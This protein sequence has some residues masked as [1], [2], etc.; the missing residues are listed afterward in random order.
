[1]EE[2]L[3]VKQILPEEAGEQ[4]R[5]GEDDGVHTD[6]VG[7]TDLADEDKARHLH[8]SARAAIPLAAAQSDA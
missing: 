5:L 4:A 1:M 3:G 7:G 6:I 8:S 2:G